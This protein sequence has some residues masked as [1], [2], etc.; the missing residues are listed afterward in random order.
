LHDK[1]P[2]QSLP[3]PPQLMPL[4]WAFTSQPSSFPVE[5]WLQ[6]AEPKS[7]VE[8]HVDPT[9]TREAVFVP[10]HVRPQAPQ[11][12]TSSATTVSQPS[13][14]IGAA[15]LIQLPNPSAH[16]GVHCPLAHAV[17]TALA[18]EQAKPQ[19]PQWAVDVRKSTSQPSAALLLQSAK[20]MVQVKPHIPL[21][22]VAVEFG[23]L[24]HALPHI[25]QLLTF[26]TLT[27]QPLAATM[28]QSAKPAEHDSMAHFC[29][30]HAGLACGRLHA[31]LQNPQFCVVSIDV[32][33]PS[34][35]LLLQSAVPAP[36][37]LFL[38]VPPEHV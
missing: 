7:H 18:P 15:G 25:P 27:S 38:H 34:A 24:G 10:E 28:S 3:Q 26:P 29:A 21:V 14:A 4:V 22:H 33:Q 8:T 6:F 2:L 13:S 12:K 20:P 1:L 19:L 23:P 31:F 17:L 5:G 11:L 30:T 36:H 35:G 16:V 9:H 37:G 32:S